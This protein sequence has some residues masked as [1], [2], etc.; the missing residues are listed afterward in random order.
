M[1]QYAIA[2]TLHLD[3]LAAL[4]NSKINSDT[5]YS[6]SLQVSRALG[7]SEAQGAE[8]LDRLLSQ[9]ATEWKH[10][11]ASLGDQ[12]FVADWALSTRS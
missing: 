4:R 2:G 1:R 7:I 3:H 11:V 5:I 8:N 10:F 12:S 6:H 9:H